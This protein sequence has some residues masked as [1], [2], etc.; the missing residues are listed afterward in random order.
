M[1]MP[2]GA[3]YV[4]PVP[5][6]RTARRLTWPFLPPGLRT[7][8]EQRLGSSVV[9]HESQDAGF[10]PGFASILTGADGSK[11]FVKAASRVAQKPFAAAYA[12]EA[13]KLQI[14]GSR[15]PT[16]E[17]LWTL[18]DD[19]V[20][21][22]F[23]AVDAR[24]PTRPWTYADLTLALDLT[25]TIAESTREPDPRLRL[26]PVH[27]DQPGL[28]TGWGVVRALNPDWPHAAEA[29]KLAQ[30]LP[31]LPDADRFVH[32]DLRDDNILICGDGRVLACDWNWPGLGPVWLDAV[33][34]LA[35]AHGDGL[36]VDDHLAD[37]R[38]TRDVPDDQ[39]DTWLAALCG[40]ML[41]ARERPAP[42]S[43]PYLQTHTFWYAEAAWGLLAQR[44]GWQ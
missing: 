42:Q 30:Q 10:T 31:D 3:S 26:E 34:L 19:W 11:V 16:P 29:E 13:R 9:E 6:G 27:R 43:S 23:E 24:A 22:G 14:L 2:V 18:D 40:F 39:I 28:I 35:A 33:T 8:I 12:E 4:A 1:N 17:L 38:L 7:Q 41:E 44:R 32:S 36:D 25:E 37:H 21:L 15:I 5:H 20:V